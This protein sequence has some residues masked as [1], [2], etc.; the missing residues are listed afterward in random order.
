V[1]G[2][3]APAPD[4]ET[5]LKKGFLALSK[6]F[7]GGKLRFPQKRNYGS[8][9]KGFLSADPQRESLLLFLPKTEFWAVQSFWRLSRTFFQKGS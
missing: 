5:F 8:T 2:S 1:C 4:Q 6:T 9:K 3:V 7:D